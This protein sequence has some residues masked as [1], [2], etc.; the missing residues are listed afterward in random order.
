[1]AGENGQAHRHRHPASR[2]ARDG[3][4]LQKKCRVAKER[5]EDKRAAFREAIATLDPN[6]LV[7]LDE[8]GFSLSLSL[9]YGWGECGQP[10]V[11]AVPAKRGKNLSVLGAL[12]GEG[13]IVSMSKEGA[14]TRADVEHFFR[15]ALL[16]R[17]LPG[18]VLVLDNASIHK[19]GQLA[20]LAAKAGCRVLYLPPYSPD[21]NPIE[22]IWGFVKR[23]VRRAGP[24]DEASRSA[25]VASG[26]AA[27]T[28]EL[29]QACFR[30]CAYCQ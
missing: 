24:R 28:A 13:M 26:L 12:D 15:V 19:G 8:V 21:L 20:R 17:L 27:V 9:L 7:F 10:L 16:P 22:L 29:A 23:S 3:Q 11:E 5:D 6:D 4:I 25:A 1:L 30:H 14:M 18:S 2:A